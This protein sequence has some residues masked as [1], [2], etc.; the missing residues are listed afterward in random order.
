MAPGRIT[1]EINVVE[2]VLSALADSTRRD[3][4]ERLSGHGLA[5][6]TT[7]AEVLPISRQAIV[8]HLAVLDAAGLV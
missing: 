1:R 2:H 7:L 8:Q 5:T 4:L 3:L 6:A